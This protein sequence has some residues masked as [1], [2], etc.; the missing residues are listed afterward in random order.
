M[1][2]VALHYYFFIIY[3]RSLSGCWFKQET[4]CWCYHCSIVSHTWQIRRKLSTSECHVTFTC[5]CNW[6]LILVRVLYMCIFYFVHSLITAFI[7][8]ISLSHMQ[9]WRHFCYT[10]I[11]ANNKS[12]KLFFHEIKFYRPQK[13]WAIQ[14]PSY[15][16]S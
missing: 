11:I 14:Y 2:N 3:S 5:E 9:F 15:K 12:Q 10:I 16:I 1:I 7:C 6:S 13:F 4:N 8:H